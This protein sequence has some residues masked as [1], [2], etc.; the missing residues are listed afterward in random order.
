MSITWQVEVPI[1]AELLQ[2]YATLLA[3]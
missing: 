3:A 2:R 1:P